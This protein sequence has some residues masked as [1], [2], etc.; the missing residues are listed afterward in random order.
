VGSL[1]VDYQA[2]MEG[3][4]EFELLGATLTS[5]LTLAHSTQRLT[6]LGSNLNPEPK[7]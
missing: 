7:P 4:P 1:V 5:L 2:S 6:R 3:F